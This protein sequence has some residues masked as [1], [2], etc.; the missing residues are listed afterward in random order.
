MNNLS[1]TFACVD[2]VRIGQIIR[3]LVS[4]QN[5]DLNILLFENYSDLFQEVFSKKKYDLA[6]ISL[7][8]YIK[9]KSEGN[10]TFLAIPVFPSRMFRHSFIFVNKNSNIKEP[11]QL[12]NKVVGVPD[13]TST[14]SLWI[15]GLLSDQYGVKPEEIRWLQGPLDD[16]NERQ[17]V[18]IVYK[19]VSIEETGEGNTLNQMLLEEKIQAIVSH[20]I[21][22]CF[23][24]NPGTIQRLFTNYKDLEV[25]YYRKTKIFPIMHTVVIKNEIYQRHPW[26][27]LSLQKAF[28]QALAHSLEELN[29]TDVL[30]TNIIWEKTALEE[31]N[32]IFGANPW[33][34]GIKNNYH[35]LDTAARYSYE[36]GLSKCRMTVKEL[37]CP[38]TLET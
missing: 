27:A 36:Q 2:N 22:S 33:S 31:Q 32:S 11:H 9:A 5:I 23:R 28:S 19:D 35:V 3:K 6:E 8:G 18:G 26:V 16:I 13:Y 20:K 37:F 15:K 17:K 38:T 10:Q 30:N 25:D 7:S 34:Y 4:P 12:K 1:M 29:K 14:A 24:S 21:P